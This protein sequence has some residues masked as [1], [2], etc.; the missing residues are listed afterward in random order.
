MELIIPICLGLEQ[1]DSYTAFGFA[2]NG[3]VECPLPSELMGGDRSF[4]VE[5]WV[6]FTGME[7]GQRLLQISQ[8]ADNYLELSQTATQIQLTVNY[9]GQHY[10]TGS[11]F[12]PQE[13]TWYH[14]ACVWDG[15]GKACRLYL[16]SD[17]QSASG[18]GSTVVGVATAGVAL[19]SLINGDH[20]FNGYL[21]EIRLWNY[22]RLKEDIQLGQYRRAY[23]EET[24]LIAYYTFED[25]EPLDRSGNSYHGMTH[26]SVN[27]AASCTSLRRY[28]LIGGVS[29]GEAYDHDGQRLLRSSS[30]TLEANHW[31]HVAAN[32]SQSYALKFDGAKDWVECDRSVTLDI[33][34]DLTIEIFLQMPQLSQTHGLISKGRLGQAEQSVPYQLAIEPGGSLRF[35]FED[36]NGDRHDYRS[37]KTLT[38]G[39]FHRIA[40]TRKKG[41][42]QSQKKGNQTIEFTD[43]DGK[44][45]TQSIEMIESVDMEEWVDITFYIDGQTAGISRYTGQSPSGHDGNLEMGRNTLVG[46][47]AS[48]LQGTISEVRL[49]GTARKARQI[50]KSI[51][52]HEQGLIGWW[53]FEES[54]G[55]V[56]LDSKGESATVRFLVPS[57]SRIQIQQ[58][59]SSICLSTAYRWNQMRL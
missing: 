51:E 46:G 9:N 21:D 22:P 33:I 17:F 31:T 23:F 42:T 28:H 19:G 36:S 27:L 39:Q 37:T 7:S 24:G 44:V 41:M 30:T 29:G 57:G 5:C 47:K 43:A 10:Q 58:V 45:Q 50:A 2:G 49:W 54:E 12:L 52:G 38:V 18:D 4:T 48:Y 25:Q 35:T 1:A 3:R 53:R 8:D 14:L 59:V 34:D 56:V 16:N 55:N 26:G 15:V 6:Y 40:V 20:S 11:D 32:F 13:K